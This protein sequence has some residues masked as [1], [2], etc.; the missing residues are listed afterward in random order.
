MDTFL[1][2]EQ[3]VSHFTVVSLCCCVQS[4]GSDLCMEQL[5]YHNWFRT[6]AEPNGKN[7][8]S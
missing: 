1:S 7:S 4:S 3:Q 6:N 8:E 5:S 2:G